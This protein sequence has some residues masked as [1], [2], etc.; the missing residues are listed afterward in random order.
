MNEKSKFRVM[1]LG[2][3]YFKMYFNCILH[4]KNRL[5]IVKQFPSLLKDFLFKISMRGNPLTVKRLSF[6]M[7]FFYCQSISFGLQMKSLVV[8]RKYNIDDNP[9][10]SIG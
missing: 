6:Q 8:Q 9:S 10:E 4:S 7:L 5:L 2:N 3:F 1:L